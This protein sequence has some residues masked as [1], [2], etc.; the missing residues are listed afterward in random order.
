MI[1]KHKNSIVIESLSA[2]FRLMC[3]FT[4]MKNILTSATVFFMLL[5]SGTAS[6]Q[7]ALLVLIFGEKAATENFHFSLKAGVNYSIINGYEEGTNRIG[8]NFGLGLSVFGAGEF[9]SASIGLGVQHNNYM[10]PYKGGI[11]YHQQVDSD[12]VLALSAWM[13][14]KC[15]VVNIPM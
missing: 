4:F 13:T 11:R 6:G 7:A 10:G 14:I 5:F 3:I 8:A 12:E 1:H 9:G 15:A 2:L